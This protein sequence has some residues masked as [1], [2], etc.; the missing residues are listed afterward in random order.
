MALYQNG[1]KD[2]VSVCFYVTAK[3]ITFIL[4]FILIHT[5]N[6]FQLII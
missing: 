2:M 3:Y 6:K 4:F 1:E 5:Y